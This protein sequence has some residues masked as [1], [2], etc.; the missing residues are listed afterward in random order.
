MIPKNNIKTLK[1]LVKKLSNK[2]IN[3]AIIGS[4]NL[5]L[6]GVDVT[7]NDI[8]ILTNKEGAF[9]IGKLLKEFTIKPIEYKES[10][11]FK[12]Y[13]GLFEINN[14][15]IEIMGDLQYKIPK[16]D[17]WSKKSR[18]SKKIIIKYQGLNIPVISLEQGYIAYSKMGRI[19]KA[20]KI[21]EVLDKNSIK[22][23]T[24]PLK[25]LINNF[26]VCQMKI[27]F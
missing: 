8:D 9:L 7:A 17:L 18:L 4:T 24:K 3:W 5:A 11:R 6:Q 23:K 14:I 20:N 25:S 10:E 12:S 27:K 15:K 2:K 21:K 16:G 19:E 22:I 13:Y 1:I 26:L